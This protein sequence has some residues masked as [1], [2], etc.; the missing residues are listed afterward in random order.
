MGIFDR[1]EGVINSYF[2]DFSS[3]TTRQF[4]SSGDPDLDA[5][6]EELNDYLNNSGGKNYKQKPQ[7]KYS[8]KEQE[9]STNSAKTSVKLPPEEL[10]ADFDC[11]GVPFGTGFDECKTAY[12]KLLKIHHPDRHAGHEKNFI[13]ATKRSAAINA[14]W[15]KIEKYYKE[16]VAK[17]SHKGTGK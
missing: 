6:Y 5:A 2:N 16:P 11:L 8:W 14:S 17:N 12:K 15:D 13:K 4:R 7:D 10:R 3:Q 9:Q 1:L